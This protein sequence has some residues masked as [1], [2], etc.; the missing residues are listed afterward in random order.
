MEEANLSHETE[1]ELLGLTSDPQLQTLLFVVFLGMYIIILLGNVIM[2]LLIHMS[3][4]L[5]TP[6]YTLLKSLSFL[7]FC[8]SSTVVPQTLVNFLAKRKVI[9]Y[10]GCMAQLFFYAGFAT[11]ECYLIAAMAYDRYAAICNP[12]LYAVTM[13]PEVCASLIAGSFSAGFLN[14][15]IH[16]SCIFSLNFCGAHVV[17]HFFCDG[18]PILS[19]SCVD[20][21]LCEILLFIF[22]SFNLLSCT[23]T[24]LASYLL[25]LITILRMNSTQGRFKAFSTCASH[26]TV[27]CLFYGSTLFIYLR[28]RSSY[29]LAQDQR[30]AVIYTVVIPMLN[31]LIY[32]L[33]NKDVKE[34]LKKLWG[35]KIME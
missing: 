14:S 30:V 33:R 18:P 15:L 26:L 2:F 16:T 5:N 1:F 3:A 4:T 21:S 23:L 11:S 10:L 13:S 28:P 8:Y 12:L 29:S 19:L 24:I 31:P 20:T 34:A 17:T 35:R 22:A 25:I 9:S 32:S 6:M 7:D 27:V